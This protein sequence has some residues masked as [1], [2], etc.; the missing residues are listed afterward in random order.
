[1]KNEKLKQ[2]MM[3]R[4]AVRR[5]MARPVR[6]HRDRNRYTRKVKHREGFG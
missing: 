1:M 2:E 3:M 6:V 5:E 4:R